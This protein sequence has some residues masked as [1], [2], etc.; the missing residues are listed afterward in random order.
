MKKVEYT[1]KD[2]ER[3]LKRLD[4]KTEALDSLKLS[5]DE[6][7]KIVAPVYFAK[8][9]ELFGR[10]FELNIGVKGEKK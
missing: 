3:D 9:I 5:T 10:Y 4:K 7:E 8:K 6:Q 1:S 2:L